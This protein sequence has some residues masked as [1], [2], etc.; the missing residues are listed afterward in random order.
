MNARVRGKGSKAATL[1]AEQQSARQAFL[2]LRAIHLALRLATKEGDLVAKVCKALVETAGYRFAAIHYADAEC[3]TLRSVASCGLPPD[4]QGEHDLLDMGEPT[5]TEDIRDAICAGRPFVV[6]GCVDDETAA[7]DHPEAPRHPAGHPPFIAT[8]PLP[9]STRVPGALLVATDC[10][11][12]FGPEAIELLQEAAD[13]LAYG[14]GTLRRA[15]RHAEAEKALQRVNRARKTLSAVNRTLVRAAEEHTLLED[16]CR[17]IVEEGGYRM[18]WVGFAQHDD[19]KTIAVQA[20]FGIDRAFLDSQGL[21]WA[22]GARGRGATGMAIRTGHPSIG[23]VTRDD[24]DLAPWREEDLSRGLLAFT[25]F[26]LRVGDEI[27]GNLTIAAGEADAFDAAEVELL[28]ELAEDLAFGIATL[29]TRQKSREAQE[30]IKRMAEE[31]A[32][33]GLP[34]R[35]R[36]RMRLASEIE[37]AK[38]WNS[39]LALLVLGVNHFQEINETLGY[40]QGDAMLC[41]ISAR[42]RKVIPDAANVAR[43]GESE[44]AILLQ[45]ADAAAASRTAQRLLL[46]LLEPVAV[47]EIMLDAGASIGT[48][49]FPG[50]GNEPD[51]LI[52]RANVAM[53]QARQQGQGHALYTGGRDRECAQRLA[54]IGDLHRAIDR[55]EMRLYCQPKARFSNRSLCG[56]E[57]LVR[58]E[59]PQRGTL[60]P[61]DFIGLAEQSG[62]I[63]PLTDWVM[64]AAFRQSYVWREAGLVMPVAVNLSARDL[65]DPKLLERIRNHFATWGADP[66]TVQFE[67]TESALMQDP[68]GC[69]DTLYRLKDLGTDLFIDDFGT[70][71]SSLSYLQKLPVDAIKIDKSFVQDML[72]NNDS[73]VIVRSTIDL[74]HDLDLEV[75]AEG[76]ENPAGWEH[77]SAQGCDV[78]Q[79]YVISEPILAESFANW[80]WAGASDPQLH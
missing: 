33:T 38:A 28:T 67:L 11:D 60:W 51:V 48:A 53:H 12:G 40:Q 36:L 47:G 5:G 4:N 69:R 8:L 39:P 3:L 64:Q 23:R 75:V 80:R 68:Q 19:A 27:L 71:Y 66:T 2:A 22:D 45:R 41:E 70:G 30:T 16:I 24:P 34:N 65:R 50:H 55:G 73:A 6:Q 56:V 17:I 62:L 54:L 77:L 14:I 37:A 49:V 31:D 61:G 26:P 18:A 7:A 44:F 32:L 43:V 57:A 74:A 9:C 76:V 1:V 79:G 72:S 29:R 59:H 42:I 21:T 63:S 35:W 25:A 46:E 78:A 58:W 20:H 13:G 15:H 52:R 10:A